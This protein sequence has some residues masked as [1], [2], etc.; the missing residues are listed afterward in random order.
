MEDLSFSEGPKESMNFMGQLQE[1]V[2]KCTEAIGD[3]KIPLSNRVNALES[4]LWAK[5]SKD[6]E[7]LDA[8]KKL[9]DQYK[10]DRKRIEYLEGYDSKH[11]GAEIAL[12]RLRAKKKFM[13]IMVFVDKMG[14]MALK[15]E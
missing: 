7:Y 12:M 9:D 14:Y 15:S 11:R 6:Q 3:T 10:S 2:K 8:S 1:L 4:F 5:I 13:A